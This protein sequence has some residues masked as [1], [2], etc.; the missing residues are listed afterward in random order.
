M[1]YKNKG[2]RCYLLLGRSGDLWLKIEFTLLT[3]LDAQFA[4]V[5]ASL[6]SVEGASDLL[7]EH[8]YL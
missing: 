8:I 2:V 3:S 7:D 6:E 4:L 5:V 1:V